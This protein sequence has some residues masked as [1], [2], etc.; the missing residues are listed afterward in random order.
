M[1]GLWLVLLALS[2]SDSL[3]RRLH[4]D[5]GHVSHDCLVKFLGTS[6]EFT[7]PSPA[8]PSPVLLRTGPA[9]RTAD[10]FPPISDVLLPAGRGPPPA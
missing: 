4:A 9:P 3:H 8:L 10:A 7:P 6:A 1:L 2:S 5:A